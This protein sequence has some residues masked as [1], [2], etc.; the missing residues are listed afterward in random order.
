MPEYQGI[1]KSV[2][3]EGIAEAEII[4]QQSGIPGAPGV[5]VCHCASEGSRVSFKAENR[6][7]AGVGDR[8]LI[9]RNISGILKNIFV[10]LG[11]PF[12]GLIL[13]LSVGL[14]LRET[15][16]VTP[17]YLVVAS[18]LGFACG[19]GTASVLYRG[20]SDHSS[21][22]ITNI[23]DP[24]GS[25]PVQEGERVPCAQSGPASCEKCIINVY[26]Q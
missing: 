20:L 18:I 24:C 7:G 26:D 10:F 6:A 22:V 3:E 5:N 9:N 4:P 21:F 8:V 15:L 14:V 16:F 1:I 19:I 23:L 12:L 13:G 2:L 25:T 17:L 11:V